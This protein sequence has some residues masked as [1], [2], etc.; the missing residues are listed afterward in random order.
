MEIS[1]F[2]KWLSHEAFLI[3]QFN[4]RN[5]DELTGFYKENNFSNLLEYYLDRSLLKAISK[6]KEEKL[7]LKPEKHLEL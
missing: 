2:N 4:K 5:F 6:C 3:R 7:T 1:Q